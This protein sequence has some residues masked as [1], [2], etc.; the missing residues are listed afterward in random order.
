MYGVLAVEFPFRAAFVASH[1]FWYAV[2]PYLF[3]SRYFSNFLFNFFFDPLIVQELAIFL[4][5]KKWG[6]HWHGRLKMVR[7]GLFLLN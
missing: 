1:K 2:F 5:V 6:R 7:W 3:V 4:I